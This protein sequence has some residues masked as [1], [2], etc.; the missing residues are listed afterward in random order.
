[1]LIDYLLA[2]TVVTVLKVQKSQTA[3]LLF[4]QGQ[5]GLFSPVV[6]LNIGT[7]HILFM[8]D[9]WSICAEFIVLKQVVC[10][11]IIPSKHV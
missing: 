8:S 9:I 7:L 2:I 5:V 3:L 11:W 6:G 1:M 10:L 4:Y